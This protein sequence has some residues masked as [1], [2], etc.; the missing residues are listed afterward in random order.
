MLIHHPNPTNSII[1]IQTSNS[2]VL[3]EIIITD[4]TGKTVMEQT[5][6]TNQVSVEKLARG[7]YI[8]NGYS[9]GNKFQEKFVKE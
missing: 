6:N 8:L 4:L 1:N 3:D 9:E 7:V 2:V 5:Q